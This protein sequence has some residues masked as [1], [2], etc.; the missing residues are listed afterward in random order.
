MHLDPALSEWDRDPARA[1]AELERR[2]TAG[3]LD[4]EVD[5]R[6]DDRGVEHLGLVRVIPCCHL[7]TEV[8]LKHRSRPLSER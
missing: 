2:S 7:I 3:Q 5:D 8:V 6:V 1:D 4:E